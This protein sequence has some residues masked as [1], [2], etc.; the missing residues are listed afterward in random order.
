VVTDN[1]VME[2]DLEYVMALVGDT[3][4]AGV[5]AECTIAGIATVAVTMEAVCTMA[6]TSGHLDTGVLL[7]KKK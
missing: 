6:L 4:A 1:T 7:A 3:V 5:G 2:Q